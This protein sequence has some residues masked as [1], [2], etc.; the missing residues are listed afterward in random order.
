[1]GDSDGRRDS[2]SKGDEEKKDEEESKF[3]E[4]AAKFLAKRETLS[5]TVTGDG[6]RR[7]YE[8]VEEIEPSAERRLKPVEKSFSQNHLEERRS[9]PDM[10][11]GRPLSLISSISP[12]SSSG[13]KKAADIGEAT[14]ELLTNIEDQLD[15]LDTAWGTADDGTAPDDLL[16][17]VDEIEKVVDGLEKTL[18]G[19][20]KDC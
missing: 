13:R 5:V 11:D 1:M 10:R 6:A 18:E 14:K 12:S 9:L 19:A 8:V 15:E 7:K 17:A 4:E 3:C 20:K 2:E 16:A